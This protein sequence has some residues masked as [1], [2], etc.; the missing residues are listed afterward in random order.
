MKMKNVVFWVKIYKNLSFLIW[1]IE[2]FY[3]TNLIK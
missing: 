2:K 3:Q 1:E